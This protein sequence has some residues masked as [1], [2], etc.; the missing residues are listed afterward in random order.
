MSISSEARLDRAYSNSE[1]VQSLKS[2]GFWMYRENFMW[3][4]T[5]AFKNEAGQFR[6]ILAGPFDYSGRVVTPRELLA[7]LLA[8]WRPSRRDE[9]DYAAFRMRH[10]LEAMEPIAITSQGSDYAGTPAC[11]EHGIGQVPI[12]AQKI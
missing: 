1:Q 4:R 11:I 12:R 2:Q 9:S 10:E 7:D 6:F 3:G 5:P 8:N